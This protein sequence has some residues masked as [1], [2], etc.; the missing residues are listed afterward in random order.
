MLASQLVS[1]KI[2]NTFCLS[3]GSKNRVSFREVL[4]VL[5]IGIIDSSI[6]FMLTK[7]AGEKKNEEL[8]FIT[9]RK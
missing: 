3:Q 6:L 4:V 8:Y 7:A 5:F 1:M 2:M 9:D